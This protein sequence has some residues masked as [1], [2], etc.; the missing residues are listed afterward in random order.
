MLIEIVS[1]TPKTNPTA[2]GSYQ[3]LSVVYKDIDKGGADKTKNVMSFGTEKD[4]FTTL[5]NTTAGE[6][7]SVDLVKE[8]AYW[9]WKTVARAASKAVAQAT[10]TLK[11]SYETSEERAK[12]QIYIVR[13]SSISSAIELLSVGA[14]TPPTVD[15]VLAVAQRFEGYVFGTSIQDLADDIP[16]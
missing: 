14:K 2:R 8:G 13:Q 3:S 9:Q 7:F 6:Q 12:K 4:T 5:S 16:E 15:D 11:S 10:Q 1:V